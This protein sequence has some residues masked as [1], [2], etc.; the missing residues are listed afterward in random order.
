MAP[1]RKPSNVLAL[2]GAFKKNP[3]RGRA[4]DSEPKELDP[5]GDEPPVTLTE[6]EAVCYRELVKHCAAG[7]LTTVDQPFVEYTAK[8][9]ATIRY[10]QASDLLKFGARLEKCLGLLG[11]T[12][13]DRSRVQVAT[14]ARNNPHDPMSEFC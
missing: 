2:N 6:L 8:V 11:M 1:P 9:L 3:S 12:P 13:A 14:G 7:V 5:L 10:G 4:R